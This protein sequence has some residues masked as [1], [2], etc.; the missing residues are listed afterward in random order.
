MFLLI[1]TNSV[2]VVGPFYWGTMKLCNKVGP[3]HR[4]DVAFPFL[5]EKTSQCQYVCR[6]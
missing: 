2:S 4:F 3:V 5:K 6:V 1:E